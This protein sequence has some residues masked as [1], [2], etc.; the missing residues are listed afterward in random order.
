[1]PLFHS[2]KYSSV[3]LMIGES[4]MENNN[5]LIGHFHY[6][7]SNNRLRKQKQQT[8]IMILNPSEW[9][10]LFVYLLLL[11]LS[12]FV[13][14]VGQQQQHCQQIN[15]RKIIMINSKRQTPKTIDIN[16]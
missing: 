8:E 2:N 15:L 1:M 5:K 12:D 14:L 6:R 13:F 10:D 3:L 11:L 9:W 16:K 7:F 4:N